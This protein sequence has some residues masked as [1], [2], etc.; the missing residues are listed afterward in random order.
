M[1]MPDEHALE[2]VRDRIMDGQG[3]RPLVA[4]P[5]NV[6]PHR[7]PSRQVAER[8]PQWPTTVL[9]SSDGCCNLNNGYYNSHLPKTA[10]PQA[11]WNELFFR[12]SSVGRAADC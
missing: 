8:G 4:G 6:A 12:L 7:T 1:S 5:G 10:C 9:K 11:G 3:A 2:S